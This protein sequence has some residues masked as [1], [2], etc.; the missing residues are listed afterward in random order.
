MGQRGIHSNE[1]VKRG[2]AVTA[3]R[4]DAS[5][6]KYIIHPATP[7][8]QPDFNS[9]SARSSGRLSPRL[10]IRTSQPADIYTCTA[11]QEDTTV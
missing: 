1:V 3:G 11:R 5:L 10:P 7:K 9:H 8:S 2:D 6:R 4:T